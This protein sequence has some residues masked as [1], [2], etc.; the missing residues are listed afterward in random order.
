[1]DGTGLLFEP[2]LEALPAW[3]KPRV[4][5]YPP[6]E[7]L[8]YAELLKHVQAA[9]QATEEFV[10]LAESFSGPLALMLAATRPRG[11]RGVVLCA[12]FVRCPCSAPWRWLVVIARPIC[13]RMAPKWPARRLLLGRHGSDRMH[14]LFERAIATVS[15]ETMA[16]RAR[17]IA[18]VDVTAE[19]RSCRLPL[20]YLLANEDRV[21]GPKC[22][23]AIQREKPDVE[24]VELAAPHLLLQACPQ[25]ATRAVAEFVKRA[26]TGSGTSG[27]LSPE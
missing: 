6:R 18:G 9:C 3:I 10:V 16:G 15:A 21:V 1:M 11:L 25:E 4:V 8:G 20:L 7:P 24:V 17:A 27:E 14:R 23:A 19:L 13:I 26:M 12:S 5:A 22:L 2:L